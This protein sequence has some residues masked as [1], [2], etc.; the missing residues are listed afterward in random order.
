MA[1]LFLSY[2]RADTASAAERL[3]RD[4]SAR[5]GA[6]QVFRDVESIDAGQNF[7]DAI[8]SALTGA[9][10]LLVLIGTR[11][12]DAAGSSERSRLDDRFDY[13]RRELELAFSLDMPVIPV[14]IDGADLPPAGSLPVSLRELPKR[15]A[16]ALSNVT[17]ADDAAA[18]IDK[19]ERLRIPPLGRGD[20]PAGSAALFRQAGLSFAQYF[21]H[22]L[23]LLGRPQR[24]LRR[25]AAD[26]AGNLPHAVVFFTVT[27]IIAIAVLLSGYT[28]VQ[29]PLDFALAV[30]GA[31]ALATLAVS[32]PLWAAWR[33]AGAK[34]HYRRLLAILMH[35][36]A[37]LHLAL[38]ASLWM[39]VV[40]FDL[41]SHDVVPDALRQALTPGRSAADGVASITA[42]LAPHAAAPGVQVAFLASLALLAASAL[43]LF[44]S[45]GA[46]RQAFVVGRMRSAAAFCAFLGL[47]AAAAGLVSLM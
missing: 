40:A 44:F 8:T 38:L 46:Y 27:L 1:E 23:A 35:Q 13:V 16:V 6:H 2:R 10:A 24:V 41:Q 32:V 19:L 33:L 9:G 20:E 28:P 30:F 31:G 34:R 15:N 37:V 4:L 18:L 17:W 7:E 36:S 14:L 25:C 26:H 45:W 43:W 22:L 39:V 5:F 47:V 12:L 42:A 21:P 29:R 11:W 3:A